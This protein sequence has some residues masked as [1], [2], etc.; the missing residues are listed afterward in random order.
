MLA[1]LFPV[2]LPE[3][4]NVTDEETENQSD[5]FPDRKISQQADLNSAILL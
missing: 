2:Y 4:P 1:G 3:L 5:L